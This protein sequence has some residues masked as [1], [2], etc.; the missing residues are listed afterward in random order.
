MTEDGDIRRSRSAWIVLRRVRRLVDRPDVPSLLRFSRQAGRLVQVDRDV[1]GGFL[2]M[3]SVVAA[4][5]GVGRLF[6]NVL[7]P[8]RISRRGDNGHTRR[9]ISIHEQRTTC[10]HVLLLR[11]AVQLHT[12]S[13]PSKRSMLFVCCSLCVDRIAVLNQLRFY[14]LHFLLELILLQ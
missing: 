9:T 10:D 5:L 12:Y 11:S 2:S 3:W 13:S 4:P 8:G 7:R 1:S 14:Q 6:Q